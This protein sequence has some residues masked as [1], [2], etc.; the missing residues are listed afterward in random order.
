M[1]QA[2]N[3]QV[4]I[5]QRVETPEVNLQAE[6][7]QADRGGASVTTSSEPSVPSGH[8]AGSQ[9][10]G[11]SRPKRSTRNQNPQYIDAISG[12]GDV[13]RVCG[14]GCGSLWSPAELAAINASTVA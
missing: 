12:V 1:S 9:P 5:P 14:C 10:N 6:R 8:P 2:E 4:I 7:N 13:W 11:N 3:P